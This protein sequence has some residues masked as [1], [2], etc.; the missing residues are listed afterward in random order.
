P[1]Q[2]LLGGVL[3]ALGLGGML[4][5]YGRISG[6]SGVLAG[7]IRRPRGDFAWR[8]WFLAGILLAALVATLIVPSRFD[9]FPMRSWPLLVAAGLLVGFGPRLSNGC[10]SGHGICGTSR[11]SRRSIVATV[12]FLAIASLT[13]VAAAHL[14]VR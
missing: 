4:V 9:R 6:I 1:I 2:S 12:T 10:T 8:A 5:G 13:A 14:G 7:V 11:L 3:I